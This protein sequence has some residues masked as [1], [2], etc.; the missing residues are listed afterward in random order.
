MPH[1]SHVSRPASLDDGR[2]ST[3]A[4]RE[5][6]PAGFHH[7][8]TA[9][10]SPES[11]VPAGSRVA[12]FAAPKKVTKERTI[13]ALRSAFLLPAFQD[14]HDDAAQ[15]QRGAFGNGRRGPMDSAPWGMRAAES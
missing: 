13:L 2:E 3:G 7:A 14:V 8:R 4:C 10:T 15:D 11:P 5:P 1:P 9:D 12:F 6:S